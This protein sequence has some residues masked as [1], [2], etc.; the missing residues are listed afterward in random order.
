EVRA[1]V[2]RTID[3]VRE[4]GYSVGRGHRW[5]S[6]AAEVLTKE[7][8]AGPRDSTSREMHRLISTLP[9]DYESPSA[10]GDDIR[11]VSRPVFGPGGSVVLVLSVTVPGRR[12]LAADLP[13]TVER[14]RG[15]AD[16][17]T[18]ALEGETD[19]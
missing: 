17:V 4:A 7:P 1:A 5:H 2:E 3:E 6:Q 18:K 8:P 9:A 10:A 11:T 12:S 14:L 19:T 13:W 15:A 16:A